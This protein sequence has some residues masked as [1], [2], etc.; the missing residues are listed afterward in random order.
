MF[1]AAVNMLL[2]YPHAMS[3]I[4]GL[5]P[6]CFDSSYLQITDPKELVPWH[7]KLSLHLQGQQSHFSTV[8]IPADPLPVQLPANGPVPLVPVSL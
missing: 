8:K 2:Q 3:E 4:M 5:G 1:G 7:V 6:C